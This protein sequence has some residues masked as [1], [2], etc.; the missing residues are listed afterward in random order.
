MSE[1][2]RQYRILIV[3][4]SLDDRHIFRRYLSR[5]EM[6]SFQFEEAETLEEAI[7]VCSSDPP[8]CVIL[9]Y[10]LPDGLGT[11]LIT[12]L[13]EPDEVLRTAVVMITG[14][15]SE[16]IAVE[17]MKNGAADYLVKE[18]IDE[19]RLCH[20][21]VKALEKTAMEQTIEEQRKQQEQLMNEVGEL[22][23]KLSKSAES[24]A[25]GELSAELAHQLGN[26]LAAAMSTAKRLAQRATAKSDQE[27]ESLTEQLA[28]V[29]DRMSQTVID[30]RRIFKTSRVSQDPPTIYFL[31][32]Q[33][34]AVCALFT[35]QFNSDNLELHIAPDLPPLHGHPSNIQHA[36]LN[37]L[38]NAAQVSGKDGK[39][40]INARREENQVFLTIGDNGP[41][42][43][44]ELVSRIFDPFYSNREDGTGLGLSLVRR[45]I[46]KDGALIRVDT[47]D[48]GGALFEIA[49]PCDTSNR[50]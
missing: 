27:L 5:I 17:A 43:P 28:R 23:A 30:V 40:A 25:I 24:A 36:I 3:D 48:L 45:N 2:A 38:E 31:E 26:P 7:A 8:D 46:E 50:V 37:L 19:P 39:I 9:D 11:E 20:T 10:N 21:V 29:L 18:Q 15:G 14:Q 1:D 49:F 33:L 13:I 4:D 16:Q 44:K 42:I 22:S 41:G 35:Q 6:Y 47:S 32:E 12:S 34:D